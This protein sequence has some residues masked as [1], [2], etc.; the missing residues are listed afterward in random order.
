[1]LAQPPMHGSGRREGEDRGGCGRY[2]GRNSH[3]ALQR[4]MARRVG[5]GT[6]SRPRVR[7]GVTAI[8][9]LDAG[10]TPSPANEG[11][12]SRDPPARRD[13][14]PTIKQQPP[15]PVTGL[16]QGGRQQP[17]APRLPPADDETDAER[18][19]GPPSGFLRAKKM[20]AGL[21]PAG[22]DRSRAGD[23]SGPNPVPEARSRHQI[24]TRR[25]PSSGSRGR[26]GSHTEVVAH[27]ES[28]TLVRERRLV[29]EQV[30][31]AT[32][33]RHALGPV[34]VTARSQV[35]YEET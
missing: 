28:A 20:P 8:C 14:N 24:S 23:Y 27:L 29:V 32:G 34:H 33:Q 6:A 30:R 21:R 9:H 31:D 3:G 25:T 35:L 1:M 11:S 26:S 10:S 19:W 5:R 12:K 4:F 7:D 15:P 17:P 16:F 18:G 22:T 2:S 13:L